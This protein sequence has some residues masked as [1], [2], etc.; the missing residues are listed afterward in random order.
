VQ[1]AGYGIAAAA[2]L[3]A[4]M[5]DGHDHLDRGFVFGGVHVHGNATAV[6]DDLNAAVRLEHYLY[7][8]AVA[9][10]GLVHGVVHHFVDKVVE[11]PRSR[12]AD[13]HARAL[14]HCLEAFKDSNVAG[15]VLAW[16]GS[17]PRGVRRAG[18]L[19]CGLSCQNIC[20]VV[21]HR[22]CRLLCSR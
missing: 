14:P 2:E 4:G 22:C 16:S 20:I 9:G 15:A 21:S 5:Q 10:Q 8:C 11:S 19:D 12:G 18:I 7:M 1:A 13:V 6:V 17:F 3:A